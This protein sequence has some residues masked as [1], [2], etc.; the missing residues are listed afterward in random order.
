MAFIASG[1]FWVNNHAHILEFLD[2]N[3]LK[4][5]E[6]YI[7]AIDLKPYITGG[8]QPKLSQAN[9]SKIKVDIPSIEEQK[10][11]VKKIERLF[12]ICDALEEQ[13]EQAKADSEM[14]MQ[15][16]LREAFEG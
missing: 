4:Y 3:S 8:F 15:A 1:K 10:E 9:L 2:L 6:K 16:I 12:K 13:I 14:L 7:N 5:I 11:I